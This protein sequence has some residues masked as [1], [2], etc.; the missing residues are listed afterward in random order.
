[1]QRSP[2]DYDLSA[3][4]TKET[5]E[6]DY[7][8]AHVPAFIDQDIDNTAQVLAGTAVD[9]PAER[10]LHVGS[11]GLPGAFAGRVCGPRRGPGLMDVLGTCAQCLLR[12]A[13]PVARS[14][15][16]L[17][18]IVG[19]PRPPFCARDGRKSVICW[20]PAGSHSSGLVTL[21][22]FLASLFCGR[23]SQPHPIVRKF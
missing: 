8:S 20:R 10:A 13:E 18:A 7:S 16:E 17:G 5:A 11:G 4:H 1:M 6:I 9:R 22:F 3:A 2:V 21:R 23:H 15:M 14:S 12:S 19:N